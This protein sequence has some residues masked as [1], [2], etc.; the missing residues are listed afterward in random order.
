MSRTHG[1]LAVASLALG[2]ILVACFS[3]HSEPA[4]DN[5][6]LCSS[7]PGSLVNGS[8]LVTIHDF[9]FEPQNVQIQAGSSVV[10]VNCEST[11]TDHNS[12]SDQ[13]VWDS[14]LLAPGN[15]FT[16]TFNSAGAY[17]YHCAPHPFMTATV[18]VE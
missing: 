16:Q 8:T 4:T 7:A 3:E 17:P 2:A 15:A 18:T 6:A 5:S 13:G 14:P 1:R 10:W 11:P 12:S 9:A